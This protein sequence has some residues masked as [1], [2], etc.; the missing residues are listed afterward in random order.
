MFTLLHHGIVRSLFLYIDFH[1]ERFLKE[2]F[3]S[4]SQ[5][6][7]SSQLFTGVQKKTFDFQCIQSR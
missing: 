7:L 5:K 2:I 3:M 1:V 4:E 6:E